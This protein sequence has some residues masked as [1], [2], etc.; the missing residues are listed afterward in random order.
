MPVQCTCQR[1]G[2]AF[3]VK[4]S[5]VDRRRFC[6]F[7]CKVEDARGKPIPPR[8][9]NSCICQQCGVTFF[10]PPVAKRKFCG[11]PCSTQAKT[12]APADVRACTLCGAVKPMSD[13]HRKSDTPS[14]RTSAC[15]ECT[16]ARLR[17]YHRVHPYSTEKKRV[18]YWEN[19][20]LA[21]LTT[22]CYSAVQTAIR[23]GDLIRPDT[24]ERCGRTGRIEAA[25]HDYSLPLDVRWLCQSCHTRWDREEPKRPKI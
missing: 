4:P 6:S 15:A 12:A 3:H 16:N 21:L 19:H 2:A 25:H 10:A 17:A 11:L 13:F 24:C 8:P 18:W 14:G 1:C 9:R 20:E 23:R 5:H 7:R 22:R